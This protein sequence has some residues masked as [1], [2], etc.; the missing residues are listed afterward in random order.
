M[1][2]FKFKTNINSGTCIERVASYL[3]N[4]SDIAHWQIDTDDAD[5]V[6]TVEGSEHLARRD[7]VDIVNLAGF[8]AYPVKKNLLNKII[9]VLA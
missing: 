6:L 9:G 4:T 3:D 8:A 7:V 2:I 1:K 5:R